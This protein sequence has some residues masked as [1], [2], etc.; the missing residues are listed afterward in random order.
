[1]MCDGC[2]SR[3]HETL[4]AAKGVRSV[5]VWTG[6]VMGMAGWVRWPT[7]GTVFVGMK[8]A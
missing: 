7:V 2:T 3:V 8:G 1:M 6:F 5:Q 4:Q